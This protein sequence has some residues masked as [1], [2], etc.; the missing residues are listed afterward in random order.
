MAG[1][2]P[3]LRRKGANQVQLLDASIGESETERGTEAPLFSFREVTMNWEDYFGRVRILEGADPE[4]SAQY[5]QLRNR[6]RDKH[7]SRWMAREKRE[8]PREPHGVLRVRVEARITRTAKG[9]L[10]RLRPRDN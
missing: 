6:V 8:H 3:A 5:E 2:I 9:L 10:H 7:W 1:S 4:V